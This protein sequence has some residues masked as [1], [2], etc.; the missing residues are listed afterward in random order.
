MQIHEVFHIFHVNSW[1]IHVNVWQKPLQYCKVISLQLIK[2]NEKN[3][4]VSNYPA[5]KQN[6]YIKIHC[7]KI[8][9]HLPHCHLYPCK[10]K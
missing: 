7:E 5:E 4:K 2:I 3:N 6:V 10:R 1:L 9:L 8:L